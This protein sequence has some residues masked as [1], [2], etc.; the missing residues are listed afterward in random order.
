[1]LSWSR[2]GTCP[3]GLL[4]RILQHTRTPRV[5]R[6]GQSLGGLRLGAIR[7]VA[8]SSRHIRA[9]IDPAAFQI[10]SSHRPGSLN[11]FCVLARFSS[12]MY[13]KAP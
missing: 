7:R 2:S 1:M 3:T 10:R 9:L 13:T 12:L 11:A 8:V 4:Q 5:R 6:V